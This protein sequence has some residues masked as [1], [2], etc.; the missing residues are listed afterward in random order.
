MAVSSS[1]RPRDPSFELRVEAVLASER[2]EDFVL[3]VA[4][5]DP[6]V[7]VEGAELVVGVE[8][9][10]GGG[11]RVRRVVVDGF[12][13]DAQSDDLLALAIPDDARAGEVGV[14]PVGFAEREVRAPGLPD[15]V[16]E[17]RAL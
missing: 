11:E 4:E 10:V 7:G 2:G 6:M 5:R 17:F 13:V 9:V 1:V 8:E 16:A 3:D 12:A 14:P 15:G